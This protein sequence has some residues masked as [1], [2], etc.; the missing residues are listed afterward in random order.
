MIDQVAQ[1]YADALYGLA[2]R[3]GAL[4]AVRADVARLASALAD[5]GVAQA[6]VNPRL[7]RG[8]RL[9]KLESL[10]GACHQLTRNFVRLVF[11]KN[12]EALLLSL[13]R[14]FAELAL[15]ERGAVEG[16]VESARPLDQGE[17]ER[18]AAHLG[19]RLSKTVL[20]TNRVRPELV[21]GVR[22]LVAS[23]MI[24]A[25]VT[26]RLTELRQRLMDAPLGV[27]SR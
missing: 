27:A 22:I 8:A 9:A 24:D 6:L 11:D 18:L 1:R 3:R 21:G 15:E 12:R 17:I 5:R 23:S 25:T 10:L 13:G 19:A 20:L 4:E 7:D 2:R 16:T 26:G 14:A